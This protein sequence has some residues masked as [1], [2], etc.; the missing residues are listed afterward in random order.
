MIADDLRLELERLA[1][2][3]AGDPDS[4]W[5]RRRAARRRRNRRLMRA[6]GLVLAGAATAGLLQVAVSRDDVRDVPAAAEQLPAVNAPVVTTPVGTDAWSAD[7]EQQLFDA[8]RREDPGTIS[9][10]LASGVDPD[11]RSRDGITA[12]IIAAFRG[13]AASVEVLV[14]AGASVDATNDFDATALQLAAQQGHVDVLETLIDGGADPNRQPTMPWGV[15]A[16]MEAARFGQPE[17]VGALLRRGA[18]P[19]IADSFGRPTV[20]FSLDASDPAPVL[21]V[22]RDADLVLDHPSGEP[23]RSIRFADHS[24]AELIEI[25][26]ELDVRGSSESGTGSDP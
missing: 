21:E 1:G 14:E 20:F 17:A 8:A 7:A 19:A 15:T 16:L 6:G 13:D 24:A 26:C 22:F 2:P 11:A 23:E 25:L 12:L 10:L 5:I 4:A 18:D 3:P 9:I